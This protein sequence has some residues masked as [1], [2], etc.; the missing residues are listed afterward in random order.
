MADGITLSI[1]SLEEAEQI[2]EMSQSLHRRTPVHIKID[3]GM[4]RLGL[5]WQK[6]LRQIEKI[7]NLPSLDIEGIYTH[8]P[9]AEKEDGFS[10]EQLVRL[11]SLI[12][13]L[14][15]KEIRFPLRHAANSA[16]IFKTRSPRMNMVRPGL[17]LY[18][19]YPDESI[20]SRVRVL[21]VLSLK[22]RI[23]N[24]KRLASGDSVG[25]GRTFVAEGSTNIAILPIGYSQ[26]YPW[27]AS[28]QSHVIYKGKR[29]AIA[30][31]VSMDYI[32]VN[33]ENADARNGDEVTLIGEENGVAVTVEDIAHWTGTI[34]YEVV[35]RLSPALPRFYR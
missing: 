26:G 10:Q 2:S 35:T 22:S 33:V 27:R 32:A 31:R 13:D 9:T 12:D 28:G 25:Y 14:E 21:P 1:A 11:N 18:G 23:I 17:M 34:P 30:G 8:F 15:K 3:T 16:G 5:V 24:V 4:G 20:R 7:V 19:L 29:C 6:A